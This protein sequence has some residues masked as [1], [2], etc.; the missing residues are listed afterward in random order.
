LKK[1]IP[2][3]GHAVGLYYVNLERS[4]LRKSDEVV[5]ITEDFRPLM[6]RW[7]IARDRVHVI[8]NWAPLEELPLQP[9]DNEWARTHQ[10][11]EEFCFLY[12]GTLGL[13]HNPELLVQ[14]AV[15]FREDTAVRVVV[16]SQGLGA[17]YLKKRRAELELDNLIIMGYQPYE[18]LPQVLG[19]ADVLVALLEPDAGVFSVP[20]KVLTYLCAGRPLLLAVPPDNLAARIVIENQAG[21]VVHPSDVAG[22]LRSAEDLLNDPA[23]RERLGRNARHYAETH[24]DIEKITDQF[25]KILQRTSSF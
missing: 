15:R 23:L 9:K 16:I 11:H 14:L 5:L 21:L 22:F 24:F 17:D 8:P 18:Q 25:E 13:K 20:S 12:S 19:A 1:K 10:L 6:E 7:G 3:F 2:G 4:L